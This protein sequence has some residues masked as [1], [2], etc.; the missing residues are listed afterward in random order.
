MNLHFEVPV[1]LLAAPALLAWAWWLARTSHA[2]LPPQRRRAALVVRL[3]ISVLLP[4][5]LA[6]PVVTW[7]A[8]GTDVAFLVDRSAS[9]GPSGMS[10][11]ERWLQAAMGAKG[12]DDRAA[13][14]AFGGTAA[15][16]RPLE[17]VGDVPRLP[18]PAES[19]RSDLGAAIR[20]GLGLLAPEAARR[21]VL[22]SDGQENLGSARE[23]A[24]LA[25]AAG[26]PIEVVAIGQPAEREVSA[27][28][29]DTP[30]ALREGERF[31]A[32]LIVRSTIETA[33]NL[34]AVAD[35]VLSSQQEVNLHIGDNRFVL[36]MEPLKRGTHVFR[37]EV[38]AEDDTFPSNNQA[39]SVSVVS[40]PPAILLVE[41]SSGAGQYLA[42]GLRTNGL[43]V[44]VAVPSTT[45]WE[46][47]ALRRFQAVVLVDVPAQALPAGQ[48]QT[49]GEYVQNFGGGLV[50]VGGG[51]AYGPGGYARTRLETMLPVRMDLRGRTLS[52]S[53]ALVLAIDN[54]G[55][56]GGGPEGG[57][58]IELAKEAAISAAELLGEYDQLGVVAFE[59]TAR[60]AVH[61]Q[62][63][64]D[65]AALRQA[66][67]EMQAGGGTDVY[68]A[69]IEAEQALAGVD[70]KVK[71]II[72]LTD[73]QTPGRDWEALTARLRSEKMSLST[74]GIGSDADDVLLGQLAELANGRY[75]DGN[76]PF[77]L[78]RLLVK[79]TIQVQRAAIVEEDFHPIRVVRSAVTD[80]L[81]FLAAPPLRGYVATTPKP[82][83]NVLLASRQLDPL[84]T[85]WQYGLGRVLSWTSDAR[86]RW[87]ARWLDGWPEFSRFWSQI[88]RRAARP[89]DDP[90]RSLQVR[91]EGGQGVVRLEAQADDRSYLNFLPTRA[92]VQSPNGQSISVALPQV[93]PGTYDGAFALM[94][95]GAY[96]VQA[97]QDEASGSVATQ[98]GGLVVPYSPE[99]RALGVNRALLEEVARRTG[100]TELK[101]P[102]AAFAP[103]A[104][105]SPAHQDRHLWPWLVALAGLL[106]VLDIAVRRLRLEQLA[107]SRLWQR[108]RQPIT[109]REALR[110]GPTSTH[111]RHS[112][113]VGPYAGAAVVRAAILA[114]EPAA[115]AT[116]V[117]SAGRLLAAKQRAR[118]RQGVSEHLPSA[119][120]SSESTP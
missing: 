75:Y 42:D 87:S 8:S 44:Q 30:P 16:E 55:S 22:L 105:I 28:L 84:L 107:Q 31:S 86:N 7:S 38:E 100:G 81:D 79:E 43:E 3:I 114:D 63:A 17:T 98:T 51:Q 57:S 62:P 45:A 80:G 102:A 70:A 119:E 64:T 1:A 48:Q 60:W 112:R 2:Y 49:L 13:F 103:I 27:V 74:I 93:A 19:N 37:A 20:T 104:T 58:K 68:P 110:M 101:A 82:G 83:A 23:A 14:V 115:H 40:G 109:G 59:D 118:M 99:Y 24:R 25:A 77:D 108:V 4:L 21:M 97:S 32:T 34:V 89:P 36:P 33:A 111:L 113:Q 66:I 90:N 47:A 52:T 94:G 15:V 35:G 106:F 41:G 61:L 96:L 67:G 88:V 92:T 56:M 26:V 71:H 18:A 78:P 91:V 120:R 10:Q 11:A 29:L 50:V 116:P 72:L 9:V 117:A 39:G 73:G 54:S 5:A 85:E 6:R 65:L 69:L 76:D 46:A 53:V 12:P 95:D